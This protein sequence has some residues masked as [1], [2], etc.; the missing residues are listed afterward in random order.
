MILA[1]SQSIALA[2][3]RRVA[4]DLAASNWLARIADSN[5]VWFHNFDSAAEVNQF[6]WTSGYSGGNDPLGSGTDAAN[7]AHV[8]SGG[9]DGGGF[10]RLSYPQGSSPNSVY[11]WRPFNPLTG[12]TNG[13]GADDPGAGSL[14][15]VAFNATNGSST[16]IAWGNV[17]NPGWYGH[18]D[19]VAANPSK[20]QGTDFWVQ[21]RVRRSGRPGPPPDSGS[22]TYITGKSVWFSTTN[23][24]YTGQELVT[25]GQSVGNSDV[26]GV[27][28]RHNVYN[29]GYGSFYSLADTVYSPTRTIVNTSVN[30]RYSG[31]WDCLLYH[32]TPGVKD[33]TTTKRTRVEVWAQHDPALYPAE[34][35]VMT[36]IWDVQYQQDY[37]SG[38]NSVGAPFYP[39]W[40]AL[41]LAI[42]HN[43]STFTTNAFTFDYDQ[44]I[45]SKASIAA[46]TI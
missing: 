12:A 8:A 7:C 22:Y 39:G 26:A 13:R 5:V 11:W 25:Y 28:E 37:D 1:P 46:P 42:Y 41:L 21:V 4:P 18:A 6:R 36:K 9:V 10:L 15:P 29:A 35:G 32:V 23:A 2:R 24:S 31:G 27:Y 33:D 20:F 43:G 16:T 45:F 30:W 19:A 40:N 34:A 44:V 3:S 14:T 38:T 17:S